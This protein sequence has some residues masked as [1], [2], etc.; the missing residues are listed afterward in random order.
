MRLFLNSFSKEP[1]VQPEELSGLELN[2]PFLCSKNDHIGIWQLD[3]QHWNKKTWNSFKYV[4]S[5]STSDH[6]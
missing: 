2:E 5:D 6:P 4:F 1:T 3:S